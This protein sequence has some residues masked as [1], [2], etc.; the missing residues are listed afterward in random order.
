MATF[1][2]QQCR[3]G[4]EGRPCPTPSLP[5]GVQG[6][7]LGQRLGAVGEAGDRGERGAA[8][9]SVRDSGGQGKMGGWRC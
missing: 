5:F 8:A 3:A 7:A 2:G 9:Q 6:A 1:C 4:A